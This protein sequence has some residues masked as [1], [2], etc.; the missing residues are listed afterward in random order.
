MTK[1]SRASLLLLALLVATGIFTARAGIANAQ[2][3]YTGFLA[4]YF[5]GTNLQ[6]PPILTRTGP[7]VN[8]TYDTGGSPA[9]GVV[10]PT[11]F[12][13]RWE[14]WYMMEHA[15]AWTITY[16][17][18]DGSRVWIDNELLIDMWFDHAPLTRARTKQFAAGYHLIRIE[19]Y[20]RTGG[21]T[22]QLTITPPGIFPDWM[23]EYFDN[24]YLLGAPRYRV[25]NVDINFNWG[26]GSPD[27][28]IPSDNFSV[29]WTRLY[30]FAPGNYTFTA[31][32]DDG[33]RVWVGDTLAIDAWQP[34]QARTYANT[35]Y[36]NG[37]MPLRV[38]Y[39]EQG[40]NA[41][42]NFYFQAANT[43]PSPPSAES[44]RGSYFNTPNLIP[45]PVCQENSP[46][47]VFNWNGASPACGIGGQFFSARWDSARTAPFTGFYTVNL[48][49]DDGARVYLDGALILDA[50]RE[51]P[52]TNYAATIYLNAGPHNW[53]VE[54]FQSTGGSQIALT[55]VPGVVPPPPPSPPPATDVLVDALGPGWTQGGNGAA[56]RSSPNGQG[57][58][59]L[60]TY[61]NAFLQPL[62]NWGRW[63]P[64]LPQARNYQV[65]V[66]IP[67]GV[68]TTNNARYW[69]F[70]NG[71]YDSVAVPQAQYNNQWVSLGTFYFA[72][73]GGENVSLSDVT[74][75]CY[76]C[77]T[78]VWDAVKFAAR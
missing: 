19:Y 62:Y 2:A 38:E 66:F 15:G 72:G 70:H 39:F 40:G 9:P 4:T 14:G 25:N 31:T 54:Y 27:P 36:L 16:T 17:S 8:W 43:S 1:I 51:Q 42:V 30:N 23:G 78:I 35:L 69:I 52:P 64:Q 76:L 37:N 26:S 6:G 44:W 41:V 59:S 74:Y 68:A 21:M 10:P 71:Q 58:G 22:S 11:N 13:T 32:A 29:R 34:Q 53:R 65:F 75:E 55:I 73:Q 77:T 60:W 12:S 24:P 18:D 3:P 49:V 47:L 7:V 5:N 63:F 33:I 45:P 20:Q 50:W 67:A 28:R 57:G 61:N 48:T 46:H 56:W